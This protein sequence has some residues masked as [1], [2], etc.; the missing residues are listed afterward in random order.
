VVAVTITGRARIALKGDRRH[1]IHADWA[2]LDLAAGIIT[3]VCAYGIR[4]WPMSEI[5][6]IAWI[7][8][9]LERVA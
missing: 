6:K 9:D 7:D 1:Y 4:S 8:C 2:Q 3:A 5:A